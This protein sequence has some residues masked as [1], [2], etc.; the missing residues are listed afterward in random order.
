M[1]NLVGFYRNKILAMFQK[2]CLVVNF[3]LEIIIYNQFDFNRI[4]AVLKRNL[5]A[6]L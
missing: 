4:F 1:I 6:L 3:A 5:L 2:I